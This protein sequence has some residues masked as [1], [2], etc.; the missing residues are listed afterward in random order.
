MAGEGS[1]DVG[2]ELVAA[3]LFSFTLDERD[4]AA[5]GLVVGPSIG[6]PVD[7]HCT[8]PDVRKY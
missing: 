7:T 8:K 5:G 6:C 3:G 1:F 2:L 4:S